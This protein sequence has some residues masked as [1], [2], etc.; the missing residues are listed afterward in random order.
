MEEVKKFSDFKIPT[1]EKKFTGDRIK[2]SKILGE[3]ILIH[4]YR[5]GPSKLF[6]DKGNGLCLKMQITYKEEKRV[7][8]TGAQGLM[9]SIEGVPK[10]GFPFTATIIKKDDFYEFA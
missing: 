3:Q 10:D 2:A 1:P 8:F 5:I 7:V 4:A 9:T 6:K